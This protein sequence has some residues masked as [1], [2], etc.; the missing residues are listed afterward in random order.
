MGHVTACS[1]A[2]VYTSMVYRIHDRTQ[3]YVV[4][5]HCLVRRC[6]CVI[7]VLL[8]FFFIAVSRLDS[9]ESG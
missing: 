1:W 6:V 9:R 3:D 2:C 7:L 5:A 8:F 4:C